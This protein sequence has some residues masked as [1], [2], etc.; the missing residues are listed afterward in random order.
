[1]ICQ[2]KNKYFKPIFDTKPGTNLEIFYRKTRPAR[3]VGVIS[4]RQNQSFQESSPEVRYLFS[5][6]N[7]AQNTGIAMK[8]IKTMIMSWYQTWVK[9]EKIHH[10]QNCP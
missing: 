6:K 7:E 5:F 1:M 10:L 3:S 4:T 2:K 9:I 8:S